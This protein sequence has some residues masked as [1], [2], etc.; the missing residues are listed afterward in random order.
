METLQVA[1]SHWTFIEIFRPRQFIQLPFTQNQVLSSVISSAPYKIEFLLGRM[2]TRWAERVIT[3]AS[4]SVYAALGWNIFLGNLFCRKIGFKSFYRDRDEF[5][6]SSSQLDSTHVAN[7]TTALG[8]DADSLSTSSVTEPTVWLLTLA[9]WL[10]D[11]RELCLRMDAM[12]P[13]FSMNM[14][15]KSAQASG[16]PQNH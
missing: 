1:N 13:F 2:Y 4:P 3:R 8:R 15:K 12:L 7:W 14:F 16:W 11:N 6:S 10:F 9:L 5:L